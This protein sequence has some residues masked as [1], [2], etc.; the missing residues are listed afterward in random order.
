MGALD[1]VLKNIKAVG[2]DTSIFI[3]HFEGNP[4]YQPIT[5][6]ILEAVET[7]KYQGVT[8]VLT[9]LEITTQPWRLDNQAAARKYE[10]LLINFPNLHFFDIDR[11]AARLAAQLRGQFRLQTPDALQVA[12]AIQHGAEVFLTNDKRLEK[13][14]TIINVLVLDDYVGK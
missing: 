6:G 7:G 1:L 4:Y 12:V 14:K 8:S 2:L 9:L 10:A 5:S 3:Y 13:I 11:S